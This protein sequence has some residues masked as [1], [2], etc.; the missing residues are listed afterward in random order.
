MA[1]ITIK[2]IAEQAKVSVG[3]VDRV[4]HNRGEV[5]E[6]TKELVLR[7]AKEGNYTTNVF[8]RSLKLG[9]KLRIGVIL[10]NDN[11]Y[12]LT[13][14]TGIRNAADQ[15]STLGM[16]V[17]FFTF[18]RHNRNSFIKQSSIAL[19]SNPQGIIMAP[20]LPTEAYEICAKIE[21]SNIPYVFVDSN[22]SRANALSFIG[23][24]SIQSGY[25]AAKLLN[26]GHKQGHRSLIIRYTDFDSLN[27]TLDERIEGFRKFYEEKGFDGSLIEEIIIDKSFEGLHPF[28]SQFYERDEAINLFIPNS[29]THQIARNVAKFGKKNLSRIIGYDL[30]KDN[31]ECLENEM[32]D[33]IIHQN[34]YVQGTLAV[35]SLYKKLI[36]NTEVP[37]SH[38]MQLDIITKENLMYGQ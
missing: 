32:I 29:R 13:Q 37:Q 5:S 11:E 20:L 10:P 31:V 22:L 8:A 33:F 28:I 17:D 14:Q 4:L 38:F 12:W 18:D 15:Y 26:L 34:P 2:Q 23:Q 16:S 35:E 6:K 21:S 7:I 19:E 30:V 3:T 9:G 27:K 1:Q 36:L 25:L 24:D